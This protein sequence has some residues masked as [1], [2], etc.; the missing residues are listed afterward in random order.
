[1]RKQS[2][3]AAAL[4]AALGVASAQSSGQWRTEPNGAPSAS[5]QNNQPQESVGEKWHGVRDGMKTDGR[6]R[7]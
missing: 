5:Q 7:G 2:F 6:R 1:M 3:L 4:T